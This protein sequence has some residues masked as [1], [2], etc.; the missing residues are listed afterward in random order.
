MPD[1]G[2]L[3]YWSTIQKIYHDQ[4]RCSGMTFSV[5]RVEG[6][7]TPGMVREALHRLQQRHPLLRARFIEEDRYYRFET[8]GEI[9]GEPDAGPGNVPLRVLKRE[10]DS[11]WARTLEDEFPRD[12]DPDTGVLWRTIL[13][14]SGDPSDP[15]ELINLIHHSLSDGSSQACFAH[16]LLL[17]C[18]RIAE[19]TDDVAYGEPLPLLPAAERMIPEIPPARRVVDQ[20]SRGNRSKP[21]ETPWDFEDHKPLEERRPRC[22]FFQISASKMLD[23]KARCQREGTTVS[24]ALLAALLLSASKKADSAH[25]VTFS[26]AI[27]LRGYCEPIVSNEHFGCFIMME[28]AVLNLGATSSFWNL[29]RICGTELTKRVSEKRNQ[30][31]M[32]R[33]FHKTVLRLLLEGNLAKAEARKQ[34]VGG[35]CLSNMGILDLPQEYGAF[36]LKETYFGSPHPSGL[37]SVFLCVATL[38]GKLFCALS[39]T[40]P[41]LSTKTAE[42]IA[43]S[44]VSRLQAASREV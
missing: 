15:N 17:A 1:V 36:K 14:Q 43:D 42:S 37:Y 31:F 25:H 41:L 9:C 30:G 26:F 8:A 27:D 35:P 5:L 2:T 20:T 3:G 13:L 28:Q 22:L 44:F 23:L 10:D 18:S 16:D 33:D 19:G 39:Y 38:H 24:S 40:E 12:F 6:P 7:L 21:A 11:H 4:Y 32:P 34:F 29:A